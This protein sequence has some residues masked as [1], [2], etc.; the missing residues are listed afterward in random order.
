MFRRLSTTF[1]M[2]A[3][4]VLAGCA[5]R[6]PQAFEDPAE[7]VAPGNPPVYLMTATVKN[8]YKTS[9]E[10]RLLVVNVEKE[11]ATEA[12]DR[13]NFTMDTKAKYDEKDTEAGNSYLLRLA[14]PAGRYE[15]VGLTSISQ[16][17]PINAMYFAPLH[18]RLEAKGSGVYYLGHVNATVRE[19]K[20]N[21]FKAGG[22]LPLIDQAVAGAST[23]TWDIEIVDAW[24]A[25][26]ALFRAQFPALKDVEVT[27][28]I[29][30]TWDRVAAQAWWEAH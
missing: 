19:R 30:P 17:F 10:P 14:L 28:A 12:A 1:V 6:T 5:T 4:T 8:V 13:L 15:I 11:G 2:V 22:P 23:G 9:Y 25:D 20:G 27:K 29:L 16:H 24:A 26:E 21:E 7:R 3:A 18:E